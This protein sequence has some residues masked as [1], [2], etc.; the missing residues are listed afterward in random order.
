MD[1]KTHLLE[2]DRFP[3]STRLKPRRRSVDRWSLM[4]WQ[5]DV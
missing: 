3:V 5:T 4:M 1:A 2:S